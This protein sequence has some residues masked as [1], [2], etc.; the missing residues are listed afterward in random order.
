[1]KKDEIILDKLALC[2]EVGRTELA[3]MLPEPVSD[4][5]LKRALQRLVAAGKV[6]VS[7]RARA[8]RYRLAAE[9]LLLERVDL[10]AYFSR[11]ADG[12]EARTQYNPDL[13]ARVLP[14]VDLFTVA[15]RRHLRSL[16][17]KYER[18]VAGMPQEV[19]LKEM[20]R[21]GVDL[22]WK[23]SQ[24]E[25]NTYTLLETERLLEEQKTADGRTRDEATML[26]NHK[27]ALDDITQHS[28]DFR[29][30]GLE[31]ISRIHTQLVKYLGVDTL[32]RTYG[33]GIGGT[34][35]RPLDN[36]TQI[37]RELEAAC[38]L[39]NGTA[40]VFGKALLALALISYIQPYSDGNK[41]TARLASNAVLLARGYCPLSYR[42]VEPVDFKRAVL[43]FYERNNIS[44]IKGIFMEQFQ[45]AVN[46]YF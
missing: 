22:S 25:G 45:D 4:A 9:S 28:G 20:K 17:A 2:G 14:G 8:T 39:V 5:T 15:E 1:M 16:Q 26:L 44:A 33:V 12:R 3:G 27:D 32:I 46:R 23:S 24:I 7:G 30:L 31:N 40:C 29:E 11:E 6:E 35:Y 19:R 42:T 13:T 37:R 41:R 38:R 21:L 34:N 18:H 10:E 36:D 43:L